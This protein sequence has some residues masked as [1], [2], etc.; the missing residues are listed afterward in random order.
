MDYY[1]HLYTTTNLTE[2]EL[3]KHALSTAGIPFRILNEMAVQVGTVGVAGMGGAVIQVDPLQW[4]SAVDLLKE[5]GFNIDQKPEMPP[6]L[7]QKI[8]QLTNDIPYLDLLSLPARL[9]ILV[10]LL[11]AIPFVLWAWWIS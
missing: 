2:L 10:F 4:K 11:F 8:E 6:P 1:A 9:L 5:L 3:V 7:L